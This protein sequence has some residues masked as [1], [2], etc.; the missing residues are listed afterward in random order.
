MSVEAMARVDAPGL[1][2]P[3]PISLDECKELLCAAVVAYVVRTGEDVILGDAANEGLFVHDAYVREK[4]PKSILCIPVIHQASFTGVLYLE[5]NLAAGAFTPERIEVLGMLISQAAISIENARLYGDLQE[6]RNHLERLVAERTKALRESR[7]IL[8]TLMSNLPGMAYRCLND[9]NRTMQFVSDGVYELVAYTPAELMENH[10]VDF[11]KLIHPEDGEYV[12]KTVQSALAQGKAFQLIY[13]ILPK[14]GEQKWVWEQG[15]GVPGPNGEA[16]TLEGFITDITAHKKMEEELLRVQKL[17]SIGS[18]TAGIAHDFN[19]LLTVILGGISLAQ[20]DLEPQSTAFQNLKK[21]EDASLQA[22]DLTHQFRTFA[23]G[24]RPVKTVGTIVG[25]IQGAVNLALSGS[26]ITCVM[27]IP[28]DLWP[29]DCDHRQIHHAINCVVMN[30]RESMPGGGTINVEAGNAHV[31]TD[32]VPIPEEGSYIK[33]SIKDH[34]KGIPQE[35]LSRV[36]DPYFSTKERGARK[37]MGLGLANAYGII[38]QH[39]GHVVV[40]SEPDVGTRV[41]IYLPVWEERKSSVAISPAER[42]KGKV[43]LMDDE[44]VIRDMAVQMLGTRGY[45]TVTAK[46]GDESIELYRAARDSG[47]PFDVVILD[48]TVR[49]GMGGKDAV[50]KLIEMDASIKAIVSSGYSDDPIMSDFR[51]YGFMAAVP[52]PY[53]IKGLDDAL[54]KLIRG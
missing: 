4:E 31:T 2:L 5:N 30:A 27:S 20:L 25:V 3:K 10:L 47:T 22:R 53:T 51:R 52:K 23:E 13:R 6:H 48:L 40:E 46:T 43:L 45:E 12:W 14:E 41:H 8:L 42:K 49:G 37:G 29:V 34:G 26:N 15:T 16:L 35:H 39:D 32:Q 28:D 19:N 36:F 11:G 33:I 54:Q 7:R 18:L 1:V 9:R 44:Q 24:G 21:S 50:L 38:R 17:E